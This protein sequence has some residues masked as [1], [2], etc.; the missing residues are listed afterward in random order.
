L[1]KNVYE[2]L[3]AG[4]QDGAGSLLR[5]ALRDFR[6]AGVDLP[7]ERKRRFKAIMEALSQLG[8][9]FEQNV[10]DSMATWSHHETSRDALAGIPATVLEQAESNAREA[11][12]PGWLFSLDQPTYIAIVTHA[13]NRDLRQRLYRAW[14]TRSS[15]QTSDGEKFD[16]TT[17]IEKILGRFRQR[18]ARISRGSGTPFAR[19]CDARVQRT[20]TLRRTTA[21]RLG[22][23][24]L[25]REIA[26]T[27]IF[28]L[29][30]TIAPLFSA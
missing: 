25:W 8:A 27:T 28:S 14:M 17:V 2:K 18:G 6:L 1:Y 11:S 5:L 20:G 13:E 4:R 19:Y 3:P 30:R 16:N 21:G 10:L 12:S 29:R 15:D 23:R 22:H 24:I 7:P 9:K 26:A